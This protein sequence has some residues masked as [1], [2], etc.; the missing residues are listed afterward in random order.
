MRPR[1]CDG[2][3]RPAWRAR[4]GLLALLA[5]LGWPVLAAA[6]SLAVHVARPDGK[7]LAGAVV[8]VH[9][10]AGTAHAR[11]GDLRHRP[12]GQVLHAGPHG[13]GGRV[14]GH[15][16]QLRC[17]QPPGL[18]VLAGEEVPAAP[19]PRDALSPDEV[20]HRRHRHA[21]LQHSRRHDRVRRRDRRRVVRANRA[22]R[23]LDGS[24][25]ARRRV[26]D[27][28]VAPAPARGDAAHRAE[29]FAGRD[30]RTGAPTSC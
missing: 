3:R 16:S 4:S 10:P 17:G 6:G 20:R 24:R 2:R 27:R 28:G 9:G 26:P 21:R 14:N 25:T 22:G 30:R 23:E 7:P 15:V 19:L 12:G 1:A 18:L 8:M 29:G 5:I 13:H 11:P